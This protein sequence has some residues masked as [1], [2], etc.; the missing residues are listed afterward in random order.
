MRIFGFQISEL[1][2]PSVFTLDRQYLERRFDS[3]VVD[4]LYRLSLAPGGLNGQNPEH[5]YLNNPIWRK[6]Y[7]RLED[8]SLFTALPQLVFSFPFAI[9]EGMMEGQHA[10]TI[11][12]A[13][14]RS[15]YLENAVEDLL[16]RAMP[17]ATVYR[18]VVWDDPATGQTW[19]N[20]V[21][22]LLG[23]FVFVF[24]VKSGQIN[25][26]ARRGGDLSLIKNFK[27]LF[28]EPGEQGWRLQNYL[29]TQRQKAV[30]R[31]KSDNR[32]LD[33]KLDRPK[34]VYRY[35]ICFEHFANLTSARYYLKALGLIKNATAWS[36]VL[37]LGELQMIARFLDTEVSFQHYLTRRSTVDE[38][39]DFDGDEQDILSLYLINGLCLDPSALEGQRVAFLEA[40]T[41]VRTQ[42]CLD[43][44][45][46]NQ[47]LS[48][49]S[50]L[51]CG[52]RS[53]ES[54]I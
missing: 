39:I 45:A 21:V 6:P 37:S 32:R 20:D 38:L 40:D 34:V 47:R 1:A 19:E 43:L 48:A 12:Y 4:G 11:A 23:N 8:G 18:G 33:F 22:A 24:E 31:L 2:W 52:K 16:T 44:I 50:C 15:D 7:L 28:V 14:A 17:S 49:F 3:E 5:V 26:A 41:P 13:D 29:D 46:E 30:L 42:R 53:S 54:C 9:I 51:R 25:A 10:L 36:P 35:S 27:E